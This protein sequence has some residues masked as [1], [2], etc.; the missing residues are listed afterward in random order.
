MNELDCSNCFDGD[1]VDCK[2]HGLTTWFRLKVDGDESY[3]CAACMLSSLRAE[4]TV[5]TEDDL[6]KEEVDDE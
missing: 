1:K 2:T 3:F 5:Y 4:F 6:V